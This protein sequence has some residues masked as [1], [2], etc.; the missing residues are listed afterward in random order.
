MWRK[1]PQVRIY[2]TTCAALQFD[3]RVLNLF[4]TFLLRESLFCLEINVQVQ[5]YLLVKLKYL[6]VKLKYSYVYSTNPSCL[7]N[8][9][10]TRVQV[11]AISFD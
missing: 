11:I 10:N 7:G 8:I 3:R 5:G 2:G 6:F 4:A 9:W 1:F